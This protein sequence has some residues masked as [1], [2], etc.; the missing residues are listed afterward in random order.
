[1]S[2]RINAINVCECCGSS[3]ERRRFPSGRLEL[4]SQFKKR[5]FCNPKC[6]SI[7]TGRERTIPF[8]DRIDSSGGPAACWPW[9]GSINKSGYGNLGIAGFTITASRLAYELSNGPI[10]DGDGYHGTVVRHTCDNRPCCNPAHLILGT[11]AENNRDRDERGRSRHPSGVAC[12]SA[13]L[14]EA[15]VIAIRKLISAGAKISAIARQF[16][17]S[18]SSIYFIKKGR[19]WKNV[20]SPNLAVA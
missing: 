9:T 12:H 1:M 8:W 15:E 3:Y 16:G 18:P 13:K 19:N 20:V 10:P 4:M 14:S 7:Q 2:R 6:S 17:C 11:Q 5:R